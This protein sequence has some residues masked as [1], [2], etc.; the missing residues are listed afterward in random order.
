MR[1]FLLVKISF[2]TVSW[3]GSINIFK[4][5]I[6]LYSFYFMDILYDKKYCI[7]AMSRVRVKV[8]LFLNV[9]AYRL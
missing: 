5:Y 9:I 4:W 8:A 7:K 1:D 6:N 3:S 2:T